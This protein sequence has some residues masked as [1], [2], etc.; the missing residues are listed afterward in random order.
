MNLWPGQAAAD[1]VTWEVV[2]NF[3]QNIFGKVAAIEF[4]SVF[5]EIYSP[6]I[7]ESY[8]GRAAPRRPRAELGVPYLSQ[9]IIGELLAR[10]CYGDHR[11]RWRIV[12][13]TPRSESSSEIIPFVR[14][15]IEITSNRGGTLR[16][17]RSI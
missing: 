11:V 9:L 3:E 4:S 15:S 12:F 7:I 6:A 16:I 14:G 13:N 1:V 8:N 2:M 10:R 5:R 17:I